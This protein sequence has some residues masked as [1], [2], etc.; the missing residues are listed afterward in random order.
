MQ[1][2][3]FGVPALDILGHHVDATGVR[4]FEE[5][6]KAIRE[7]PLPTSQHQLREFLGLVNFYRRF[8][9]H[10]AALLQ[11]LN[12]LLAGNNRANK[13]NVVADALSRLSANALHMEDSSGD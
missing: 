11:P 12:A 3:Q 13:D 4:P 2:S 6:V 10:C 9:P 8:L 1:K 5:K 7:F